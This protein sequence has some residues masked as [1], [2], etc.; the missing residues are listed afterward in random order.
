MKWSRGENQKRNAANLAWNINTM[1]RKPVIQNM[2]DWVG[3]L[4]SV[5]EENVSTQSH[6]YEIRHDFS[7][8]LILRLYE[9]KW[10]TR[11]KSESK[12]G[13]KSD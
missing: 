10:L 1:K 7:P 2:R 12:L 4:T 11:I 8:R 6:N 3:E 13:V 5:N 9:N